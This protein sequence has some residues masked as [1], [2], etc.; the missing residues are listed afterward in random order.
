MSRK[1]ILE[2]ALRYVATDR[3]TEYGEPEDNFNAIARYWNAYLCNKL[4]E[5]LDA[6]D[7]A[8]MMVAFKL[9]R[10]QVRPK[11]PDSAI[12]AAGYAACAGEILEKFNAL[13]A[14]AADAAVI[15]HPSPRYGDAES[16]DADNAERV[17]DRR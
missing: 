11:N 16:E 5:K 17:S 15:A 10:M 6:Y 13:E 8:C 4:I 9:A 14:A 2:T 7:V 3:N 12:D 1:E